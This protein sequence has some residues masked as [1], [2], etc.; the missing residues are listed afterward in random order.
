MPPRRTLLLALALLAAGCAGTER[1]VRGND[2]YPPAP[3][4]RVGAREASAGPAHGSPRLVQARSVPHE[5]AISRALA[6]ARELVGRREMRAGGV[7]YGDGC[8]ALVR[9]A[10][11]EAG[12]PLHPGDDAAALHALARGR[13]TARRAHPVPGD[14]AFL[15]DRPNGPAE[16]VGIVESVSPNGTALVLHRTELGVLRLRVNAG[17]PWK[18]RS[19]AGRLLNDVMIV[20]GGRV[21]AGRLLVAYATLL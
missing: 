11:A 18:L 6:T 2:L 8:A 21:P 15:A 17:A 20:G 5:D 3:E 9:A 19:E 16:H 12:R 7:S 4:S 13:G 1:A 10:F 14:L